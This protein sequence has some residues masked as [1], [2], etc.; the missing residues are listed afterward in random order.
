DPTVD[1]NNWIRK[2]VIE[3]KVRFTF[4]FAKRFGWLT[5]RYGLKESTGGIGADSDFT[6]GGRALR[7]SADVF[8]ATFDQLPRVK[9]TAALE[10]FRH[11][12]VLGGVDE[13]LNTPDQLSIVAG[14]SDVPIQFETFKFGRDYFLGGMLRFNDEDLAA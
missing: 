10:M 9:L 8:D 2:T 12:Y 13:L 14:N 6:F 5:L 7:L 1:P 11:L 4:Q 3:D